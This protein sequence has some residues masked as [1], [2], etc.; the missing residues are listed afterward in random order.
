MVSICMALVHNKQPERLAQ[1]RPAIAALAEGVREHH[2]AR[3]IEVGYQPEIAPHGLGKSMWREFRQGRLEREWSA[4][5]GDRVKT[6]LPCWL[7]GFRRAR[8]KAFAAAEARRAW[9]RVSAVETFITAKHV[10]AWE[11]FLDSGADYLVVFEDDATLLPDSVPRFISDVLPLLSGRHPDGLYVDLAGGLA[12][13]AL[14]IGKFQI[15]YDG[16]RRHYGKAVTNTACAYLIDRTLA[17]YF[18]AA[19][20]RRPDWREIAVDWL[21]NKLFMRMAHE[22][23]VC[24]CFHLD[25]PVFSHGSFSGCY[26]SWQKGG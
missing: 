15:G 12:L 3:L 23:R 9:Q 11:M 13:E 14:K 16:V 19:L 17:D 10:R 8:K 18:C 7:S 24:S 2:Q 21:L 22:G 26:V 20:I 4:Y 5:L 1:V 6:L 25:P